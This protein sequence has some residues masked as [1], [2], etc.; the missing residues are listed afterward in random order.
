MLLSNLRRVQLVRLVFTR[1]LSSKCGQ[2]RETPC[3]RTCWN[4]LR[5]F[6]S[7]QCYGEQRPIE[8]SLYSQILRNVKLQNVQNVPKCR[9][10]TNVDF[11]S[12]SDCLANRFSSFIV[13][14]AGTSPLKRKSVQ[15][16]SMVT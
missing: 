15:A 7:F 9:K 11:R 16:R 12:L 1:V 13:H 3:E 2:R 6:T 14:H 4:I 10:C 5:F 8:F